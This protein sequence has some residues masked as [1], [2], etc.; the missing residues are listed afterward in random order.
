L[1][2]QG[3]DR[4]L[5]CAAPRSP[6]RTPSG[7]RATTNARTYD[8]SFELRL[9]IELRREVD[10][11]APTKLVAKLCGVADTCLR[12]I[13]SRAA[14]R[15]A[16]ESGGH[17]DI[18]EAIL[19]VARRQLTG[20]TRAPESGFSDFDPE[21]ALRTVR[22][23]PLPTAATK[24]PFH[25]RPAPDL[26]NVITA[27]GRGANPERLAAQVGWPKSEI[28]RVAGAVNALA[29]RKTRRGKAR[30]G[31]LQRAFDTDERT[32]VARLLKLMSR[33]GERVGQVLSLLKQAPAGHGDEIEVD[34]LA[35]AEKL[36][37]LLREAG[38]A[39]ED[40]RVGVGKAVRADPR[41]S[42]SPISPLIQRSGEALAHN[43]VRYAR[44]H[45]RCPPLRR[46]LGIGLVVASAEGL[47]SLG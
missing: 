47:V 20:A 31:R 15:L 14:R 38:Y 8:H 33:E 10:W 19:K 18:T 45:P 5:S 21:P 2:K 34:G 42:R 6:G 16:P 22:V 11:R 29:D 25:Q 41:F 36:H 3:S 13:R 39:D 35:A 23:F 9:Y 37:W 24:N 46:A 44:A 40:L 28:V 1:G 7:I 43:A 27:L 26:V 32:P 30:F 4:S 17:V 12:T